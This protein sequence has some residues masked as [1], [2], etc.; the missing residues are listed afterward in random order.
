MNKYG[1]H[2]AEEH[3]QRV[4]CAGVIG[5]V[6]I[7]SPIDGDVDSIPDSKVH[8][9]NVGP[10]WVLSAPDGPHVG[11]MNLAI[12]DAYLIV[13]SLIP[14]TRFHHLFHQSYQA[15]GSCYTLGWM[16]AEDVV[17]LSSVWARSTVECALICADTPYC[18]GVNY[19]KGIE[20][21][22]HMEVWKG[23]SSP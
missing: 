2:A 17:I 11:P 1:V 20:K 5:N 14:D 12:K 7:F 16:L 23:G 10:T 4:I 6:S 15:R 22:R 13:I 8:E 19:K 9:A 21:P 18:R 3:C